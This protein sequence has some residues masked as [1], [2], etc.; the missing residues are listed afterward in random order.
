M[1]AR[2]LKLRIG[3]DVGYYNTDLVSP[4]SALNG[5]SGN[6]NYRGHLSLCCNLSGFR[7]GNGADD[8][9][10]DLN[11]EPFAAA[12]KRLQRLAATQSETRIRELTT[13]AARGQKPD[14]TTGSPCLF[15]LST[16]GKTP[17]SVMSGVPGGRNLPVVG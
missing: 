2:I 9:I 3:I 1:L 15:C 17:W 7:G 5:V 11:R 12:L 4:C 6:V 8:I 10:G 13:L 16:L 14:L